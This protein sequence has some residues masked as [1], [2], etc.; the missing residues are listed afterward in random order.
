MEMMTALVQVVRTFDDIEC[1]KFGEV[2][3]DVVLR[4]EEIK[5]KFIKR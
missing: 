1:I 4:P 5:L 3:S 2:Y